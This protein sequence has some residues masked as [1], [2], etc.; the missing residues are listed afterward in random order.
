MA[1][2]GNYSVLNKSPARKFAGSTES[3]LRSNFNTPGASRAMFAGWA[4]VSRLSSIPRGDAPGSAWVIPIRAG[5]MASVNEATIAIQEG[6]LNL[7]AG[8]NITGTGTITFTEG[9]V[10]LQLIVS[11]SGTSTITFDGTGSL[12]GALSGAGTATITFDASPALLG[13]LASMSG[14]SAVSFAGSAV[15]NA[16]GVLEGVLLPYTEDSPE[17]IAR[18]VWESILESGYSAGDIMRL[19][20]AVNVGNASGLD[21]NPSFTGL[22]GSTTRAAGTISGGTRTITAIDG[23]Q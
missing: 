22:D 15:I 16:I 7:A 1:L 18:L 6:T 11:G 17:N 12:A 3:E 8:R 20:A 4:G 2:I 5:D 19:L 10:A 23:A 21:T 14:T 13:A 9:S